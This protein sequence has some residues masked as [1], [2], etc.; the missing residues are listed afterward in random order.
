MK[1]ML[2]L[3]MV[4]LF[5]VSVLFAQTPQTKPA[6]KKTTTEVKTTSAKKEVVKPAGT[7]TKPA[8]VNTKKKTK[9]AEKRDTKPTEKKGSKPTEPV[10]K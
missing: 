2:A 3:V 1:K 5:S 4:G 9:P 6:E 8:P 10:K 7:V